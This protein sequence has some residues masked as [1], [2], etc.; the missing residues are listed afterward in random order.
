MS[1]IALWVERGVGYRGAVLATSYA[2]LHPHRSST[3]A[4]DV[5][6]HAVGLLNEGCEAGGDGK[7]VMI[8]PWSPTGTTRGRIH[9]A[10]ELAHCDRERA[11]L[12]FHWR[13]WA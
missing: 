13:A 6:V 10:L 3:E 5:I 11:A 12:L 8:D 9:P 2:R 7:L 1:D 4:G